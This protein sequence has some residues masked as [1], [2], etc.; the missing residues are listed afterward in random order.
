MGREVQEGPGSQ[1]R[2]RFAAAKMVGLT[3]LRR[4]GYAGSKS[5][6]WRNSGKAD[7]VQVGVFPSFLHPVFRRRAGVPISQHRLPD[8]LSDRHPEHGCHE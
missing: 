6:V 5:E 3:G 4:R 7:Q 2:C 1:K 8:W